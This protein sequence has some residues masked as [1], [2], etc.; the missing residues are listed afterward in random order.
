[1]HELSIASSIVESVMKFVELHQATKVLAVRLAV[2][3]LTCIEA[4]QLRFC[5]TAITEQTPLEASTLDIDRIEASVNCP[6]CSYRGSPKYWDD[7]LPGTLV[8][9]LQCPRCGKAAEPTQGHECSI[10]SIRYVS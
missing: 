10:R 5:Y 9:T 7:A 1:M 8:P 4:A 2:G 3:E 6:H